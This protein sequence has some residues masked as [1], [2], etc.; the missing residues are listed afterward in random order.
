[1]PSYQISERELRGLGLVRS[2]STAAGPSGTRPRHLRTR[3]TPVPTL[4]AASSHITAAPSSPSDLSSPATTTSSPDIDTPACPTIYKELKN[5]VARILDFENTA[6]ALLELRA[7]ATRDEG[8]QD[9]KGSGVKLDGDYIDAM[10]A[11]L[12]WGMKVFG[13]DPERSGGHLLSRRRPRRLEGSVGLFGR[14]P[15]RA[16]LLRKVLFRRFCSEGF[17][18]K[19]FVYD[20]AVIGEKVTMYCV[21]LNQGSQQSG[22]ASPGL[23][24]VWSARRS[25]R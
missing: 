19:G 23:G 11:I 14:T 18:Q 10:K 3:S 22:W 4:D 6:E 20:D 2:S 7:L 17:V 5:T 1:M 24:V 13:N 8:R 21:Q 25:P 15:R 16:S 9:G 12:T